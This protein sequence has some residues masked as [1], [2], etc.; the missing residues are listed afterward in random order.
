M[1]ETK[2]MRWIVVRT[3]FIAFHHWPNAPMKVAFLRSCHRHEFH[4]RLEIPVAHE[5][6]ELEFTL[7][8]REL[9][10]FLDV[11]NTFP[12]TA[13]CE[14]MAESIVRWAVATYP[15]KGIYRTYRCEVSE[16]GENGG[17]VE[18]L[19]EV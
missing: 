16:D 6:R 11:P 15:T 1:S 19:S 18:W 14:L 10:A 2:P 9:D 5:D 12:T 7:V 13:S 3:R 17:L 4:V 8:K